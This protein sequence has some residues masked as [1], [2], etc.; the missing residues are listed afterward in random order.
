[1][2]G[3]GHSAGFCNVNDYYAY[4]IFF[5]EEAIYGQFGQLFSICT[6]ENNT[7][8]NSRYDCN[9]DYRNEAHFI[10]TTR[11]AGYGNNVIWAETSNCSYDDSQEMLGFLSDSEQMNIERLSSLEKAKVSATDNT[12][13][14]VFKNFAFDDRWDF[15]ELEFPCL[16]GLPEITE[17][18]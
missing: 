14:S 10:Y 5:G 4:K 16:N 13:Q 17:L 2:E 3:T 9:M 6:F 15:S 8:W 11:N 18:D 7:Y 12:L 1:M